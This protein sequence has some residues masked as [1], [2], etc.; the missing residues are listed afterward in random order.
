MKKYYL[1]RNATIGL[2]FYALT[3]SIMILK[4]N[5]LSLSRMDGS[6]T[7]IWA[8]NPKEIDNYVHI[9]GGLNLVEYVEG[10]TRSECC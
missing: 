9:L 4:E 8:T 1:A 7:Q 3:N 6:L 5:E 10:K 2:Y